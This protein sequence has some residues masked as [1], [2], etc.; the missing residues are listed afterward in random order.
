M[1]TPLVAVVLLV[2]GVL[3]T[4]GGF[5]FFREGVYALGFLLGLSVGIVALGNGDVPGR[6]ALVVL[7]AAPL[8]GVAIAALYRYF[9]VVVPGAVFGGWAA[10]AL[11]GV[12][13]SSPVDSLA[14]VVITGAILGIVA[15]WFLETAIIMLVSASWGATL[16]TVALGA[17][18]LDS[19]ASLETGLL[20]AATLFRGVLTLV[21]LAVQSGIWFYLRRSLDDDEQ[22]REVVLRAAGKQYEALR[23]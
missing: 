22:L 21:G 16:I 13:L 2:V 5:L 12:S 7:V 19:A 9:I 8:V 10:M 17:P 4:V 1:L 18:L 3:L 20:A 11:S 14:P 6:W 23:S 15:A